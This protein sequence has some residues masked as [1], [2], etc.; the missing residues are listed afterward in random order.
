MEEDLDE[1]LTASLLDAVSSP[2]AS[3]LSPYDAVLGYSKGNTDVDQIFLITA[4]QHSSCFSCMFNHVEA[5]LLQGFL[6]KCPFEDCNSDLDLDSCQNLLTP[7]LFGIMRLRVREASIPDAHKI[8]CPYPRC[9]SLLS[10]PELQGPSLASSS[11]ADPQLETA[12]T[13]PTCNA[14]FCISC[15]V[16][17]HG[18]MSCDDYKRLNP[19]PCNADMAL[20]SLATLKNWRQCPNC[21][22]MISLTRGCNRMRCRCGRE[23]CYTCGGYWEAA[24]H[25]RCQI[26]GEPDQQR[27]QHHDVENGAM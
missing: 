16:P 6:P 18:N 27:N 8:Y 19:L 4:C 26:W 12:K 14:M 5:R 21:N 25:F 1:A 2:T 24:N 17:W 15:K 22:H 13:C 23:F 11:N 10:I 3:S 7:Q 9:S 20:M